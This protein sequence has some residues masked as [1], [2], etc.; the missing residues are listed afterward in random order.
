MDLLI[1]IKMLEALLPYIVLV[2]ILLF[3]LG[4][5]LVGSVLEQMNNLMDR[6]RK[7]DDS[8]FEDND[9]D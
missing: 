2:A 1:K 6:F 7:S 9:D 8:D 3:L 5:Y 4:A